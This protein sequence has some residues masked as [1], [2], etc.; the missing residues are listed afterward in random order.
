MMINKY[1]SGGFAFIVI[2]SAVA[3]TFAQ[4]PP[5]QKRTIT[6]IDRFDFGV[7][8]T[9]VITGA[10]TGSV[11]VA[12]WQKHEIEITAV[13]EL[14]APTDSDLGKLAEISGFVTDESPGRTGII[15]IGM[16]NKFGL[17]KMPKNFPKNLLGL[18]FRIDYVINVPNFCDLEIDGGKGD[19]SIAGV[20]GTMRIN[21]IESKA[22]IEVISGATVAT[23]GSG[24]VEVGIGTRGWRAR[25][26][27]IQVATGDLTV[28]LPANLN[29][30]IDAVI[31]RTGK[32]ENSLP[33]MKPRDRKVVFTDKSIAAKTGVGGVPLKFTVG[34]G[35]L[36]MENLV[37]PF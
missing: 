30:E 36:K 8:G 5:L 20:E 4:T 27:T 33:G 12:G 22:K 25:V 15:S 6:K 23:F 18:P 19:L 31:L 34:D 37:L 35:I 26:A 7:G 13:I 10:P 16:H 11:R 14:Q 2:L 17:K 21:F 24:S 1:I 3:F 32:I 29:A 9:V 28:R